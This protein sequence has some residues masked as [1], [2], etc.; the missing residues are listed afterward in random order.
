MTNLADLPLALKPT[1]ALYAELQKAYD[2]FNQELFDGQLADCILTL[3]RKDR[4]CGY[5]SPKRFGNLLDR[6]QTHEIA[7]NPA[8]FA[9][10]PLVEIMQTIVHEMGHLWQFQFGTPSR[11]GYHNREWAEKMEAIGLMPSAT[12]KPGGAKTGQQMA[13]Y[14]I[15]GGRFAAACSS[16][17]SK[18]FKISWYDRF[19]YPQPLADIK[20]NGVSAEH[21][22]LHLPAAGLQVAAL[23]G[24]ELEAKPLANVNRTNRS[25]Y[26]CTCDIAVWGKP[27]LNIVCGECNL[28]LTETE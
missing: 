10:V 3:Q 27:G 13:D 28:R 24:I 20:A 2:H 9:V 11:S 21:E 7:L 6:S 23:A 14:P 25:K 12:G 1:T 16:L 15:I 5:F 4:T 22:A 8:Y 26:T 17:L 19:G 18:D